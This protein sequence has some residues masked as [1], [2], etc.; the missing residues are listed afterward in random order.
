ME[1]LPR[2]LLNSR[3]QALETK[4]AQYGD[5]GNEERKKKRAEACLDATKEALREAGGSNPTQAGFALVNATKKVQQLEKAVERHQGS[6]EEAGRRVHEAQDQEKRE[7]AALQK[8]VRERD[9]AKARCAYLALQSAQEA[10][11]AVHGFEGLRM[12][13]EYFRCLAQ[14]T[15]EHAAVPWVDMLARLAAVL[16]PQGYDE[17]A[18]PILLGVEISEEDSSVHGL[19]SPSASSPSSSP[20]S[21]S[22]SEAGSDNTVLSSRQ[23]MEGVEKETRGE[24]RALEVHRRRWQTPEEAE[25]EEMHDAGVVTRE[26][27]KLQQNVDVLRR[28]VEANA[29]IEAQERMQAQQDKEAAILQA[30][31]AVEARLLGGEGAGRQ[32]E[33]LA[34]QIRPNPRLDIAAVRRRAPTPTGK[35]HVGKENSGGEDEETKKRRGKSSRSPRGRFQDSL[36]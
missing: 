28:A 20:S 9:N 27:K 1:P 3:K 7:I 10:G 5:G 30:K 13:V 26:R 14:R 2:A 16:D 12:A 23:S 34:V 29:Q 35:E 11:K 25:Q 24:K 33:A 6:V 36:D 4:V 22:S 19:T 31:A 21:S 18:D 8:V 15:Q 17:N 32:E